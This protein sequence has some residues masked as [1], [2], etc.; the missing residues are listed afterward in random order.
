M[1]FYDGKL[2]FLD[3]NINLEV[4]YLEEVGSDFVKFLFEFCFIKIYLIYD[5]NFY[6]FD[7]KYIYIVCN[8]FD[9][10]VFFY[11]YI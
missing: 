6:N 5:L 8:F 3:K 4:F 7:L 9:C 2:L 10:V 1:L 11:Y